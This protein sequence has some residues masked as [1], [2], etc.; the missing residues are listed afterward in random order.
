MAPA[1]VASLTPS[2]IL[3]VGRT[4][5]E[6]VLHV[7]DQ[8]E[9]FFMV[10]VF[11]AKAQATGGH[12]I[13]QHAVKPKDGNIHARVMLTAGSLAEHQNKTYQD[14]HDVDEVARAAGEA[15][16]ELMSKVRQNLPVTNE[17]MHQR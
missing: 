5:V 8:P 11:S 9:P 13:S 2:I 1:L 14:R 17:H 7:K 12:L 16:K 3:P 10:R 15:F 6:I 4:K